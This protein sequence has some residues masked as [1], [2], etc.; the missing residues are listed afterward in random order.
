MLSLQGMHKIHCHFGVF[1]IRPTPTQN[2]TLQVILKIAIFRFAD[3]TLGPHELKIAR[4]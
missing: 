1:L 4:A 3:L 2:N